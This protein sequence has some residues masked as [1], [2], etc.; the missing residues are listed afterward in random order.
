MNY[1][2]QTGFVAQIDYGNLSTMT[3]IMSQPAA[4][5]Q[6]ADKANTPVPSEFMIGLQGG[7]RLATFQECDKFGE[8]MGEPIYFLFVDGDMSIESQW[9]TPSESSNP[10]NKL[11]S[12]M[13]GLQSGTFSDAFVGITKSL[14]LDKLGESGAEMMSG[15]EGK[16][17]FTKV[18]S[19][20]IYLSSAPT[21]M[22]LNLALLAY[23][24]AKLEVE[25][26]LLK[27][28]QLAM[29]KILGD[30]L[31]QEGEFFSSTIP[32]F[33]AITFAN[34]TYK[35]FIVESV[36]APIGGATDAMGNRLSATISVTVASRTA[37]DARDAKEGGYFAIHEK[38]A[39]TQ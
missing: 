30:S 23:K 2:V 4:N 11:P 19:T 26:P 12:L 28:Q 21:R 25:R 39:D 20:Q 6:N 16:S 18:N 32:P 35:P 36:S 33:V 5:E 29:P 1:L 7:H 27:L 9:Q 38:T 17:N 37:M 22:S 13:A 34:K 15:L 14:G 8:L 3:D 24:D 10:E 31:V